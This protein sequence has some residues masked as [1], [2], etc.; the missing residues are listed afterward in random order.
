MSLILC[1]TYFSM[2]VLNIVEDLKRDNVF[3]VEF[4]PYWEHQNIYDLFSP[5]GSIF[6]AW[7]NDTSAFVAIQNPENIKKGKRICIFRKRI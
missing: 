3:Y 6:I 7:L 4:P 2:Y 1:A 5:F